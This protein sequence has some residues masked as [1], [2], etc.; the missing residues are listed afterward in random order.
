MLAKYPDRDLAVTVVW[1]NMVRTDARDRWPRDEIVDRRARHFWDARKLVGTALAGR[2]GTGG[3]AAGGMGRLAAV[4]CRHDVGRDGSGAGG[5]GADDHQDTGRARRGYSGAAGRPMTTINFG[6]DVLASLPDLPRWVEARG[7]LMARRAFVV[8]TADG[9]RLI[10]G[11]KDRLVV[12]MTMEL[13]PQVEATAT[14][15][16]PGASFLLQDVMLPA[17]RYH[18][19]DWTRGTRYGLHPAPGTRPQLANAAVADGPHDPR[20]DR[21][22][23]RAAGTAA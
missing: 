9:C 15:E 1:F 16:V 12:P 18:L 23:R 7:M 20:A 11:R 5:P 6:T 19:P 14:R 4:S 10:C 2:P 17:G 3:L 13:S 21:Q 8:D 22:G